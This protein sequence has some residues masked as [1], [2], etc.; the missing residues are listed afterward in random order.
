MT[1][2]D[3]DDVPNW[4]GR[5]VID[6]KRYAVGIIT[7]LYFDDVTGRPEWAAVKSGLFSHRV[8]FVPL[9]QA[10]L[11]GMNVQ[12]PYAK[13][14]IHEAPNIEPDGQL[15]AEEEARLYQHYG[16]EYDTGGTSGADSEFL[17]SNR[18]RRHEA[19]E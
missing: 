11:H 17:A 3:F 8:T 14:H 16:L 5:D 19:T 7:D 6:E 2:V 9:S 4:R 18:L 13:D 15:S 1:G 12:V 10:V